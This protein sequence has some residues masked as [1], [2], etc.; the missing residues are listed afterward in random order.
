MEEVS[1][2]EPKGAQKIINHW[3]PF[4]RGESPTAHMEQVYPALL[5]MSIVVPTERKG[6]EYVVL[7][8]AYACKD[9]LK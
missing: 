4:N 3:K 8:P 1:V 5:W 6:E 9:E 2:L 7:V